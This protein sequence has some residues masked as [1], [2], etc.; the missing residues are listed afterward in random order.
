MGGI[1]VSN[2]RECCSDR[3]TWPDPAPILVK[4]LE[5]LSRE[6]ERGRSPMGG[7]PGKES[8]TFRALK[9]GIAVI[10]L[11]HTQISGLNTEGIWT[12]QLVVTVEPANE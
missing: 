5:E 7:I 4:P 11:E 6:Y 8:W 10:S 3:F 12:Y 1:F 9:P 2:T